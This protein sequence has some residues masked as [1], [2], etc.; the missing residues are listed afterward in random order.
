MNTVINNAGLRT[1]TQIPI[2]M[3]IYASLHTAGISLNTF[4]DT[5]TH[6]DAHN[7]IN[8]LMVLQNQG[9]KVEKELRRALVGRALMQQ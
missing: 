2:H 4:T 1:N 8:I 9:L 5:H 6:T 3:F 7:E